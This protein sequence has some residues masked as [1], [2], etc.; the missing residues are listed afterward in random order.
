MLKISTNQIIT[1][2][3]G[4]T[5]SIP[6][7]IYVKSP[8]CDLEYHL[9]DEDRLQVRIMD[10]NTSWEEAEI[11]KEYTIEDLTDNGRII[12]R[13]SSED[14]IDMVPGKYYYEIK[15]VHTKDAAETLVDTIVTRRE[16]I[17]L[18]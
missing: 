13:L 1:M 8:I 17:I 4:D 2:N 10:Y 15:L 3:R 7:L 18:E 6:F 5:C 14:T 11:K 16:F 9:Q 12:I